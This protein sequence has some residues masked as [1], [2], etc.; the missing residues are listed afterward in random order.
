MNYTKYI[1]NIFFPI[2]GGNEIG[3]S[4]YFLQ[5][6][7]TKFLLDSGIRLGSNNSFPYFSSLYEKHLLDGL[8]DLDAILVSHGH[9]DHVGALP[10]VIEQAPKVP[11][12]TTSPTKDIMEVQLEPRKADATFV[13]VQAVNEFNEKRGSASY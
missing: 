11:I 8:W 5:L 7:G 9:L 1:P 2:G 13:D 4:S 12:Y 6:D 3:A 10:A